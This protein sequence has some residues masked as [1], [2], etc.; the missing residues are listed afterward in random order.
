MWK[1]E[2]CEALK[3]DL[4]QKK[5]KNPRYSIRAYSKQLGVSPATLSLILRGAQ[6]WNLSTERAAGVVMRMNLSR[7]STN[8]LLA[9][10]GKTPKVSRQAASL[11]NQSILTNW[12]YFAVLFSH[13]LPLSMRSA[14]AIANKLGVD[15]ETIHQVIDDL[16]KKNLLRPTADE[17]HLE[18][19]K[20][21]WTT[22]ETTSVESIR[23]H[24]KVNLQLAIK[25]I[26]CVPPDQRD[27]STLTFAGTTKNM[28]AIRTEIRN[29]QERIRLLMDQEQDNEDVM[30]LSISLF[31][32]NFMNGKS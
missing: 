27:V 24:H 11:E 16:V 20:I 32:L 26:D 1:I 17:T 9:L 25:S 23:E 2:L 14:Q 29:F 18:T 19:T 13:D 31:P 22:S 7:P 30:K 12:L 15:E 21:D 5:A 28:N 6:T 3:N 4:E 8:R 10:M